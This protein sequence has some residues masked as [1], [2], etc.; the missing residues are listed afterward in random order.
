MECPPTVPLPAMPWGL[1]KCWGLE[2]GGPEPF[3]RG[4]REGREVDKSPPLWGAGE[5]KGLGQRP[6]PGGPDSQP[7]QASWVLSGSASVFWGRERARSCWDRRPDSPRE[8]PP[9]L[10]ALVR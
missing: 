1:C 3:L 4:G 6:C 9:A 8:C 7:T 5:K 2:W 10:E